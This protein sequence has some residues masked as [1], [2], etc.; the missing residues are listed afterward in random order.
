LDGTKVSV[1][2]YCNIDGK[3]IAHDL[4]IAIYSKMAA[5]KELLS[6]QSSHDTSINNDLAKI[7]GRDAVAYE[8]LAKL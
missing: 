2:I 1:D 8:I 6:N 7:N 3:S 4:A 5:A